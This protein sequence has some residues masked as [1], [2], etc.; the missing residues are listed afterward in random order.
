MFIV[1]FIFKYSK[2]LNNK[3][4]CVKKKISSQTESGKICLCSDAGKY[5]K[6]NY[7][8]PGKVHLFYSLHT[9][10]TEAKFIYSTI[11]HGYNF[12]IYFKC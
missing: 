6:N 5:K 10:G 7:G 4:D 1:I 11:Q 2:S 9:S 3:N 8:K 12:K